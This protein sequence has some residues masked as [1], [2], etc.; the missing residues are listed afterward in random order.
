MEKNKDDELRARVE[1]DLLADMDKYIAAHKELGVEMTRSSLT[2]QAIKWWMRQNPAGPMKA[3][4]PGPMDKRPSSESTQNPTEESR[5]AGS[6]DRAN[7][8]R[9]RKKPK[10]NNRP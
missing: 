3:V 2:R 7:Q 8:G 1:A 6:S 10:R 5:G 9:K 4:I